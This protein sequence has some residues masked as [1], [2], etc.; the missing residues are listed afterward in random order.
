MGRR[1]PDDDAEAGSDPEDDLGRKA[2]AWCAGARSSWPL[3]SSWAERRAEGALGPGLILVG[4][5]EPGWV[6]RARSRM[7]W[8]RR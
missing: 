7:A 1:T 8:V 6:G 5:Y 4:T 3:A 2:D